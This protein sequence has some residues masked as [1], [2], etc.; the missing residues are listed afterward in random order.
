MENQLPPFKF[1]K[2]DAIVKLEIGAGMIER[3]LEVLNYF[4]KNLKEEQIEKYHSELPFF[5]QIAKKEKEFSEDW[6]YPVTTLSFFFQELE[7]QAD[8]QCQTIE[9]DAEDFIKNSFNESIKEDNQSAP[10]SQ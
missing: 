1:I 6:M 2:R 9:G 7:K 3:L 4:S 5:E 10:Q 8:L